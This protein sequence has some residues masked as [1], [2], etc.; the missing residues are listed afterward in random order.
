LIKAQFCSQ[1][2]TNAVIWVKECCV[3]TGC[4]TA[5]AVWHVAKVQQQQSSHTCRYRQPFSF[6]YL[7]YI[8]MTLQH[9]RQRAAPCV[10]LRCVAFGVNAGE[11]LVMRKG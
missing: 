11:L 10:F 8:S 5:Q 6:I 3:H 4:G 2:T 1:D 7:T 9:V